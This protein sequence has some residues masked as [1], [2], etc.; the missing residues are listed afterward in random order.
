MTAPPP[1]PLPVVIAPDKFKGSLSATEAAEAIAAGARDAAGRIGLALDLRLRPVADGGEGIV[2]AAAAAG[3]TLR[4][5]TVTGPLGAPTQAQLAVGT[6][7]VDGTPT[8]VVELAAGSG[9]ALLPGG[10]GDPSSALRASTYGTGELLRAALDQGVR[11]IVLGLGGSAATDGGS[12]MAAALGARFLD[13]DGHELPPGGAALGALVRVDVGGLDAR[14]ADV[15]IVVASDVDNP[16]TGPRGAAAVFGPQKGAGTTEVGILDEGLRRLADALRR[17]VGADVETTPGAG[18]AGGAGAGALALLGARLVPGI[19][20]VLDLVGFD[21]A[22][23]GARLVVTGEGSLD[24]QSLGG[25]APVGV[26]RRAAGRG[27]P[28]VMLAGRIDVDDAGR[29]VL[30]DM[31]VVGLHALTDIEPDVSRAQR[32]ARSLLRDM[33]G[34]VLRPLLADL[35]HVRP[36]T[37]HE[38]QLI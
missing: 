11:R 21:G 9:L 17:D 20:L 37:P 31:G 7:P 15:E 30:A 13:V 23:D 1:S 35:T 5:V 34:R 36:P 33:A 18:A 26:A 27:V 28:V 29:S 24:E 22:L 4:T 10:H 3:Y 32:G 38:E 19:D 2:A 14:L 25:K 6:D 12:G 16:L 8:A